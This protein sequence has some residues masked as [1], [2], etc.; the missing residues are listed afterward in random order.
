LIA[1]KIDC[2]KTKG[3]LTPHELKHLQVRR[4][5]WKQDLSATDG[6]TAAGKKRVKRLRAKIRRIDRRLEEAGKSC[7]MVSEHAVLRYA[8]IYMGLDVKEIEKQILE[9]A[10]PMSYDLGAG[11]F[12][13]GDGR[14]MVVKNRQ[15]L[16][17]REGK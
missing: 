8:E 12:P 9:L 16:T 3:P 15:V 17:I 5:Q 6:R 2:L 1:H 11:S 4:L 7:L 13:L 14:Q 10:L